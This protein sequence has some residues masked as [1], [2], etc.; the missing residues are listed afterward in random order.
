[1]VETTLHIETVPTNATI[2]VDG[3]TMGVSPMDVKVPRSDKTLLLEL[4]RPGYQPLRE[5]LVPDVDQKLRLSLV[6]AT[7][8]PALAPA[9]T[10]PA[11]ATASAAPYHRFD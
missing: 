6:P 10:A 4:R 3:T 1:V 2:L 8:A 11:T 9:P 5:S 7:R